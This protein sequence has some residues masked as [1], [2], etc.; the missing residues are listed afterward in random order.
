MPS[1]VSIEEYK[2]ITVRQM[3][4]HLGTFPSDEALESKILEFFANRT[5][6]ALSHAR[7][8]ADVTDPLLLVLEP[9]SRADLLVRLRFSTCTLDEEEIRHLTAQELQANVSA[10][11]DLRPDG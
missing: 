10:F 7:H 11:L 6:L 8:Y 9:G 3:L 5:V 2:E 1:A 4:H